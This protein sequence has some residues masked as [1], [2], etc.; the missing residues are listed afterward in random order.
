ME[1][2]LEQISRAYEDV[3]TGIDAEAKA[4]EGRAYGGIVRAGKGKLVESIAKT[5]VELAWQGLGRDPARLT[6][7]RKKVAIPLRK[8]YLERIHVPEVRNYILNN[9]SQHIYPLKTDLHVHI[10]ERFCMGIECKAYTENAMLKRILVDFTLLK[11]QSADLDCVLVQ[12]ESQ[13]TG[14]Y[15]QLKGVRMGSPSTHTLLSYFDVDLHI[16][17]LLEG[18]RK[19]EQP[20]HEAEHYKPLTIDS[21][22]QAVE[23]FQSLLAK[24][25]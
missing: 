17:T 5:L 18:E 8:P 16:I 25:T 7:P 10:E 24:H 22:S 15:S 2:E 12:L 19:V 13:L 1:R 11:T 23:V 6:F 14:D 3:V 4:T 9:I 21:L 20:I